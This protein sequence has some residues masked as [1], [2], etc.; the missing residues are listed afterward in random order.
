MAL[1]A[2]QLVILSKKERKK[3]NVTKRYIESSAL[4]RLDFTREKCPGTSDAVFE[5]TPVATYSCR[6][7]QMR[8]AAH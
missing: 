2:C 1:G 4:E 5:M 8:T 3:N 6:P 7:K